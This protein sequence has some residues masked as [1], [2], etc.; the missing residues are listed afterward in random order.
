MERLRQSEVRA[1]LAFVR[2]I[3]AA[4]DLDAFRTHLVSALPQVIRSEITTFNEI[5][6]RTRRDD[7]VMRPTIAEID[8]VR[9]GSEESWRRHMLEHPLLVRYLRTRD[10]SAH[11]IS[12]AATKHEFHRLGLYSEFFR[13][14]GIEHQLAISLPSSPD[15]M[16]GVALHRDRL[17]YS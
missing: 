9:P 16:I 6:P 2:R 7:R 3:Y 12:D 4:T 5:N 8:T 14:V 13:W 17:D 10:G 1:L 11:K 15:L